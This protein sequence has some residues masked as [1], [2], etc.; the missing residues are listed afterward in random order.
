MV[1]MIRYSPVSVVK[2]EW[3]DLAICS[4]T[5]ACIVGTCSMVKSDTSRAS[6]CRAGLT[7]RRVGSGLVRENDVELCNFGFMSKYGSSYATLLIRKTFAADSVK[8]SFTT[9]VV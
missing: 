2:H 1:R 3:S 5:Q 9:S 7:G 8:S 6:R 4:V